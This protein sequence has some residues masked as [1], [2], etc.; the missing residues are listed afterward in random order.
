MGY[1]TK[2][3]SDYGFNLVAQRNVNFQSTAPNDEIVLRKLPEAQ[4][5]DARAPDQ[6]SA[7]VVFAR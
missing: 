3:W 2:H 1:I 5:V 4:F 6:E 7:R